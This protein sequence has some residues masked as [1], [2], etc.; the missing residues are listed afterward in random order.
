MTVAVKIN[1]SFR[2]P[3][4]MVQP[5]AM[6][7]SAIQVDLPTEKHTP[8]DDLAAYAFVLYGERGIGKSTLMSLIGKPMFLSFERGRREQLHQRGRG[9][10]RGRLRNGDG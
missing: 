4:S 7:K 5:L 1:Q 3:I 10:L 6:G 9:Q 2:K 8:P